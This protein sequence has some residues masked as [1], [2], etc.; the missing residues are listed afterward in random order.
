MVDSDH[1]TYYTNRCLR[2]LALLDSEEAHLLLNLKTPHISSTINHQRDTECLYKVRHTILDYELSLQSLY[3]LV[4]NK[5]ILLDLLHHDPHA[6]NSANIINSSSNSDSISKD[7]AIPKK[8]RVGFTK[9]ATTAPS[10]PTTPA[11]TSVPTAAVKATAAPAGTRTS[12]AG[13]RVMISPCDMSQRYKRKLNILDEEEQ[14]FLGWGHKQDSPGLMACRQL[15]RKYEAALL[16]FIQMQA[17]VGPAP[18][19]Q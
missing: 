17:E 13:N 16:D 18:N 19:Q 3:P 4:P 7:N 6:P 10:T 5:Q 2:R 15:M 12:Q 11:P 14:E 1:T 8:R 9:V